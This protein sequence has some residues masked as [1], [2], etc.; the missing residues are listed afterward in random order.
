MENRTHFRTVMENE[1]ITI[2]GGFTYW[3]GTLLL[4]TISIKILHAMSELS[5]IAM[6]YQ[7]SLPSNL[8]K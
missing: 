8:K 5:H 1:M 6:D 7:A 3:P 2:N 4:T